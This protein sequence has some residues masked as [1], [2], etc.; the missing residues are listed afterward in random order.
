MAILIQKLVHEHGGKT[1]AFISHGD[2]KFE[3]FVH[4][5]RAE[6]AP[7]VD[8]DCM[9]EMTFERAVSWRELPEFDDAQACIMQSAEVA[10]AVLVQGRVHNIIERGND[11]PLVDLYLQTGPE[12][13]VIPSEKLDG[14]IPVVGAGLEVPLVGL[15]FWLT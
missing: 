7:R 15:C 13:L 6:L 4:G 3:A 11:P 5:S 14:Y 1:S 8:T 2:H 12:F 10:G 9:A